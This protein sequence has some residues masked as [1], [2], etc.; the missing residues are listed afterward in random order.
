MKL[1]NCGFILLEEIIINLATEFM[2]A[3]GCTTATIVPIH[4]KYAHMLAYI[5]FCSIES[6]NWR[7]GYCLFKSIPNLV[8]LF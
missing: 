4:A 3:L 2:Q 8:I 1:P 6:F 5:I 7:V